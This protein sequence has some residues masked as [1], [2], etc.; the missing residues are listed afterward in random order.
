MSERIV[1]LQKRLAAAVSRASWA[2]GRLEA[3][4]ARSSHVAQQVAQAKARLALDE[5]VTA[6]LER[7]NEQAH[8]RAVGSFERLLSAIVRDVFPEQGDVCLQLDTE[9]GVP[10]LD[11]GLRSGEFVHDVLDG[12]GGAVTNTVCAG[13]RFISLLRTNH[14]RFLVLDEP[15]AW[16]SPHR[17][18]RFFEVLTQVARN[19]DTQTVLI[20]HHDSSHFGPDVAVVRLHRQNGRVVCTQVSGRFDFAPGQPGIRAI[21]LVDFRSHEHTLVP[22]SAGVT[23]IVGENDVGKSSAV[24][25]SLRAV[26]YG[27]SGDDVIRDGQPRA[28]VRV[29]LEGD[30]ELTWT[31]QAKGTPKVVYSLSRGGQKVAEGRPEKRGQVPDWARAA[32]GIGL[33]E[34]LDIQLGSQKSPVFLVDQPASQQARVLSVGR[35]STRLSALM[36]AWADTKRLDRDTV[37]QGEH[38]FAQLAEKLAWRP[39][40]EQAALELSL[41]ETESAQLQAELARE[42]ALADTLQRVARRAA[43]VAAAAKAAA[44]PRLQLPQLQET[45]PLARAIERI[46]LMER[47]N[48]AAAACPAWVATVPTVTDTSD[49]ARLV[50]RLQHLERRASTRISCQALT[51]PA[52]ALQDTADLAAYVQRLAHLAQRAHSAHA[53]A[54]HATEQHSAAQQQLAAFVRSLGDSCPLCGA[55]IDEQGHAHAYADVA[56]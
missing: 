29:R 31:R 6:V 55:E 10:T 56:H 40:A 39:L 8:M 11:I 38:E 9:R 24:V 5:K 25:G 27:E 2:L 22:L 42:T 19:T 30:T 45:E 36:Q 49:L 13:L 26:A 20:S 50:A 21:E 35:E 23:A 15:D 37:R 17:V 34:G 32:L 44:L 14:R 41:Q 52:Q 7:L 4:A 47:R 33:V 48:R 12:A 1:L 16:I 53:A 46:E 3:V 43:H 18:E 28:V 51:L 54:Q